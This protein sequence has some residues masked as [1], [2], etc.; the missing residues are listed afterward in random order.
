MEEGEWRVQREP[1]ATF[2][3]RG[4]RGVRRGGGR[5]YCPPAQ[6]RQRKR[7]Q[8]AE[9]SRSRRKTRRSRR[10]PSEWWGKGVAALDPTLNQTKAGGLH[11]ARPAG[12][13][14]VPGGGVGERQRRV[15]VADSL[16]GIHP[17][18]GPTRR[19]VRSRGRVEEGEMRLGGKLGGGGSIWGWGRGWEFWG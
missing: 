3:L 18:P 5:T 7:R 13:G 12:A 16:V 1:C 19:G 9:E 10:P 17:H 15:L 8:T 4:A 2:R 11:A 6:S 14:R